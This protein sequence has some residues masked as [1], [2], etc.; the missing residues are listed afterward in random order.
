M[1]TYGEITRD[2]SKLP[3]ESV[4]ALMSRGF[5][6]Y[7]GNEQASKIV[8]RIRKELAEGKPE[9]F[10]ATR[11]MVQAYRTDHEAQVAKWQEEVWKIALAALDEGT[12]GV[13][14]RGPSKDPIESAMAT[15]A[16]RE[17]VDVLKGNGLKAPKGEETVAL[18]G[19][20]FTMDQLIERRLEKHGERVRKEAERAVAEAKRKSD[21]LQAEA[22]KAKANGPVTAEA[23]GL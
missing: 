13:S 14:T 16:R 17:V 3:A 7:M 21:R 18:G 5:A 15:I 4:K 23:L 12:V 6:H 9:V 19:H 8:A 22:A 1:L 11:D 2:E 10:E 20:S